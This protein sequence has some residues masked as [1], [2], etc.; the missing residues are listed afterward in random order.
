MSHLTRIFISSRRTSTD[1]VVCDPKVVETPAVTVVTHIYGHQF[2]GKSVAIHPRHTPATDG[3]W[4]KV[5]QR[6]SA[7]I[8]QRDWLHLVIDD[9]WTIQLIQ[10][11]QNVQLVVLKWQQL[12]AAF[13]FIA[14]LIRGTSRKCSDGGH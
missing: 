13:Y 4:S 3:A 7:C 8:W 1:V 11:E 9:S 2:R 10:R 12:K 5:W 14:R 6:G